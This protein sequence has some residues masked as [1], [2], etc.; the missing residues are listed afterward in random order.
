MN[1][2]FFRNFG[3]LNPLF[4]GRLHLFSQN[5][6]PSGLWEVYSNP[7]VPLS[8]RSVQPLA[9]YVGT[10]DFWR[11]YFIYLDNNILIYMGVSQ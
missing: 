8:L 6:P 1:L 2:I 10:T 3:V 7:M 11:L 4:E 9:S 5:Q